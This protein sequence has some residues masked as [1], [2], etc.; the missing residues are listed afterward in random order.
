MRRKTTYIIFYQ[1][2]FKISYH[3]EK[4]IR[5][6]IPSTVDELVIDRLQNVSDIQRVYGETSHYIVNDRILHELRLKVEE[7]I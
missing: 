2:Y 3:V 4:N 5:A 1:P 7:S 6:L